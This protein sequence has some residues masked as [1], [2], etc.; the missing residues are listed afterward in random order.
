MG[1]TSLLLVL[2]LASC[3]ALTGCFGGSYSPSYFPF[4]LPP[5]DVIQTHGKPPGQGYFSNFDPKAARLE[6]KPDQC[7]NPTKTHQVVVASVY[8]QD[9]DRR[10]KRR[11]EWILDG[12]G[13]IVEVDE[14]GYAPGRGY[15]VDNKRAVSYTDLFER[16]I[17]RGNKDPRDDFTVMPGQTWCIVSCAVEGQTT[18][19]AYAPAIYDR[20]KST[21]TAKLVWSDQQFQFPAPQVSRSGGEVELSTKLNRFEG[22]NHADGLKVRYRILDGAPASFASRNTS[23]ASYAGS[24]SQRE[25]EIETDDNGRAPVRLVQPLAQA[26]KTRIAVEVIKPDGNN[27]TVVDRRETTVEWATAQLSVNTQLPKVV[28]LDRETPILITV[29]NTGKSESQPVTLRATLPEGAEY[30]RSDPEPT[31]MQG[32]QLTWTLGPLNGN[33]KLPVTVTVKPTRKGNLTLSAIAETADGLRSEQRAFAGVDQGNL[34]CLVEIPESVGPGVRFT[35]A[36]LVT[37]SGSVPAENVTAWLSSDPS[38]EHTTGN[39][40]ELNVGILAPGQT[41]RLEV[42]LKAKQIGRFPLRAVVTADGGLRNQAEVGLDVRKSAFTLSISGPDR[43]AANQD[44]TFELRV[45]NAGET[46]LKRGST[47][48][49]SGPEMLRLRK[50]G[51]R[52][53]RDSADLEWTVDAIAPGGKQVFPFTVQGGDL[54]SNLK[55]QAVLQPLGSAEV[56]SES[57]LSI[58]GE[59][60][61][62]IEVEEWPASLRLNQQQTLPIT[63]RNRGSGPAKQVELTLI[64]S[65]EMKLISGTGPNRTSGRIEGGKITFPIVNELAAGSSA[66]FE[67]ELIGVKAGQ[68]RISVEVRAEHLRQPLREDQPLRVR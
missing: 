32:S 57:V 49:L 17:T 29:S 26:G 4:Y 52:P 40:T 55:L 18:V 33:Q 54:R 10:R 64:G 50:A 2:V 21:V 20:D 6:L 62:T 1:R 65:S 43:L 13:F 3:A 16:K 59:P 25:A 47:L 36:V 63:I 67:L 51:D 12:P 5:G 14:S 15:V 24:G 38:I 9:G 46:A 48:R 58:A 28:G 30:I 34:K 56:R 11:V 44:G 39:Q 27:G 31:V 60:T 45:T 37:N 41:K 7:S 61:L 42:P 8:D 53:S 68:A 35:S 66:V 22:Q 23:T 19:T